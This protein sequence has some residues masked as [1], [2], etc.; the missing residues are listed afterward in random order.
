MTAIGEGLSQAS[1]M[2][3]RE[4]VEG[5]RSGNVIVLLTDGESNTG[6]PVEFALKTVKE[7]NFRTYF[8]GVEV[9]TKATVQNQ[10]FLEAPKLLSGVKAT[11]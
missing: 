9:E 10:G 4:S 2:L 7:C 6:R 3:L 5:E 11:G 8:I 1:D